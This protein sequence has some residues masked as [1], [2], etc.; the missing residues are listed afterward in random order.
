[1]WLSI[2]HVGHQNFVFVVVG[3]A[4]WCAG[5]RLIYTFFSVGFWCFLFS[6]RADLWVVGNGGSLGFIKQMCMKI[7]ARIRAQ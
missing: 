7:Y 3:L 6:F 1:M 2:R 5:T 4:R